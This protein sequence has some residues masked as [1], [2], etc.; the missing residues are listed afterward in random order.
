MDASSVLVAVVCAV[1]VVSAVGLD[2]V[3]ALVLV[4]VED[5]IINRLN[6]QV[7][8][9]QQLNQVKQNIY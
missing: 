8:N 2:V 3:K 5:I 6:Y 9:P 4:S 7:V 1:V